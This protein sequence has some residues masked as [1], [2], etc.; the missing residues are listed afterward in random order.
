MT[1][2]QKKVARAA[3]T[4]LVDFRL[5]SAPSIELLRNLGWRREHTPHQA[6]LADDGQVALQPS[7]ESQAFSAEEVSQCLGQ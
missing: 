5:T 2:R 7:A 6:Q 4:L 3:A 1:R